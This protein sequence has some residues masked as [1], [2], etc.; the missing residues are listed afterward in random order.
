M[1]N[2]DGLNDYFYISGIECY[3]NNTLEIYKRGV[4]RFTKFRDTITRAFVS[5]NTLK[6]ELQ[7]EH[8]RNS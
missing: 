5:M 4:L 8:L 6:V 3:E 1:P 7:S 2:D